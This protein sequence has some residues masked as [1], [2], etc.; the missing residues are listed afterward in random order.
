[1]RPQ[2]R[3]GHYKDCYESFVEARTSVYV[4]KVTLS[5]MI[6]NDPYYISYMSY[7]YA[8]DA[9]DKFVL[10]RKLEYIINK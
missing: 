1:M 9:M 10:V 6:F 8:E 7:L 3:H 4:F 5:S 2:L